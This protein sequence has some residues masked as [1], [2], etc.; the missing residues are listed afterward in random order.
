MKRDERALIT[1]AAMVVALT[2]PAWLRLVAQGQPQPEQAA[3][4]STPAAGNFNFLIASGF[5]CDQ[6][7]GSVCPAV[8]KA[9]NGET[10]Q[11]TGAGTLD[12]ASKSVAAA[13][14]FT[15]KAA[16]GN[17]LATGVW[18]AT[19]LVS[20]QSYGLAPGALLAE[21]PQFRA[22]T[23]L[24]MGKGMMPGTMA[25]LMAGPVAAGGAAV[26]RIR[27]LP[28]AGAPSEALLRV[29]CAKGKP[30][31]NEATDRIQLSITGGPSFDEEVS[32][33]TMFLL[34]RPVPNFALK[35]GAAAGAKR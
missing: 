17:I 9:D 23:P 19:G 27:L 5:L 7:D 20:F 6:D 10:V 31:E 22:F 14:A 30:P 12:P 28:D 21:Y 15:M 3:P 35:N 2:A 26:F 16:A 29:V 8:A 1:I 24:A 13:G 34:R 11:I 4:R 25:V 32:G 33:R 18:T